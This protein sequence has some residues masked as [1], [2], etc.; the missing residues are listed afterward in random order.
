MGATKRNHR[1]TARNSSAT[2]AQPSSEDKSATAQPAAYRQPLRL[3]VPRTVSKSSI[4]EGSVRR[5][6]AEWLLLWGKVLPEAPAYA[7]RACPWTFCSPS[8]SQGPH[9]SFYAKRYKMHEY[10]INKC[11]EMLERDRASVARVLRSVPPDA[12]TPKRPLYRLATV[13]RALIEHASKPDGRRGN[14]DEARLAAERARLAREQADAVALKNAV[15]RGEYVPLDLV[16][17]GVEIVFTAFR[18]RCLAIPGKVAAMCEMRARGE[19]EGVVRDE[20]YEALEELSSRPLLPADPT[21]DV[22]DATDADAD[23]GEAA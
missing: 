14:G 4:S 21:S 11:A 10:T 17:K 9:L 13:V 22:G 12:G 18:E 8:G 15:A 16:M 23:D 20:I 6:V 2:E 3:L 1:A 5:S 19:V 7:G